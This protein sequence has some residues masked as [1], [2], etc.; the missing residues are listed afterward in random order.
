MLRMIFKFMFLILAPSVAGIEGAAAQTSNLVGVYGDEQMGSA[1]ATAE[2]GDLL[3]VYVVLSDP[4]NPHVGDEAKA[5]VENIGC[6]SFVLDLT[7]N[8]EILTPE[9]INSSGA[10]K[11]VIPGCI[12]N[13]TEYRTCYG[14]LIPVGGDRRI[15][16]TS[17]DLRY[18][19]PG[20]AEI[21]LRPPTMQVLDGEMDFWY[22]DPQQTGWILPMYPATGDFDLP[23]FVVNEGQ[24][25][26]AATSW[27]S[28]KSVY[29]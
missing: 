3:T 1:T 25:P 17:F 19:G 23:V 24:V 6:Y 4:M 13:C 18:V 26:T 16:L 22:R 8:L 28:V 14:F 29:R 5:E 11:P 12:G 15:T 20:P 7:T 10:A 9:L 2:A 21:R 27:G